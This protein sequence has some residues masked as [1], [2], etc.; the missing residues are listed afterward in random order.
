MDNSCDAM[1][2]CRPAMEAS[3]PRRRGKTPALFISK[4]IVRQNCEELNRCL[5]GTEI[6]YAIKANP[7]PR[8][9][10]YLHNLGLGFEVSSKSELD[11]L[12]RLGVPANR[13]VSGNP[14]KG[15]PFIRAA[16]RYGVKAF[17]F[18]SAD[19]V[20]KLARWA[21]GSQVFIRLTVSNEGSEWPLSRK[22]GVESEA[23][24]D[25][26]ALATRRGLSP[27]GITFHVGSQ[28]LQPRTW[29]EA[30]AKCRSTW[31]I[32]A[33]QGV[34]LKALNIGGG[35][36][37]EYTRPTPSTAEI[38]DMV[39]RAV[40]DTFPPG[41]RLL[42]E[43]GR[44]LVGAA[45]VLVSRVIARADRN[46]QR[47]LHLDAGVFNGLMESIGGIKYSYWCERDGPHSK[48]VLAGPSC[49]SFDVITN[50]AELPELEVGD[51]VYIKAAGAYTTAYASRFNGQPI[52]RTYLV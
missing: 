8:L 42:A 18:D 15:I 39:I 21:P 51:R 4:D 40:R 14:V 46:G 47:W 10:E 20:E 12:M 7:D 49:D 35:F 19:E 37:I 48:W 16:H 11:L 23:A 31:D 50:E 38:G 17:A 44:S 26:L 22:F 52:P 45:G 41:T 29:L 2:D 1:V 9:A 3:L 5:M 34:H 32:A 6:Y 43:P 36:P 24:G 13:M 33:R 28:C 25:L 30:I 27:T